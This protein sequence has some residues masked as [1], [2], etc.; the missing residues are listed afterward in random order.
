VRKKIK[1]PEVFLSATKATKSLPKL[2]EGL[3]KSHTFMQEFLSSM[4][5]YSFKTL[6]RRVEYCGIYY[7]CVWEGVN[8]F[9]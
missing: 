2:F 1:K 3:A 8:L 5:K 4:E 6:P 7:F 9:V